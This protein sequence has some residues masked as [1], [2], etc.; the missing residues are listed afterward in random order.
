MKEAAL[1]VCGRVYVFVDCAAKQQTI[2]L[3]LFANVNYQTH[4]D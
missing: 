4:Y 3:R 1:C 2:T